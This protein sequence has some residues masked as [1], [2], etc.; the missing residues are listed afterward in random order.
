MAGLGLA[1]PMS[2]SDT[3][4][5]QPLL[6]MS[7]HGL[8]GTCAASGAQDEDN[9]AGPQLKANVQ[10]IALRS[11]PPLAD[12]AVQSI[13]SDVAELRETVLFRALSRLNA[14]LTG[15]GGA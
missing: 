2:S 8:S 5:R 13:G 1:R 15:Y 9:R 7:K 11:R 6:S 3:G 10:F 12:D 4:D 14:E